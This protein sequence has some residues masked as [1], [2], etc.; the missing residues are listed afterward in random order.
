MNFSDLQE[1]CWQFLG[2]HDTGNRLDWARQ[3]IKDALN[4]TLDELCAAAPFQFNLTREGTI[5]LVNGTA[6]YGIDDW[7]KR[8]IEFWTADI[9]AHKVYLRLPRK[10]DRDGARNTSASFGSLGPYEMTLAPRTSTAVK[11]GTAASATEGST[12]VTKVGGTD[13]T[14][15]DIGRMLRLNGE[16]EDYKITAVGGVT[17]LTVDKA[18]KGRLSGIGTTGTGA[19]Y[20]SVRWEVGPPGR[21]QIQILPTP[22]V[23]RT[24]N[25]R[26]IVNPRRMISQDDTPEV[27]VEYHHLLWKGALRMIALVREDSKSR[28]EFVQEYLSALDILRRSDQDDADSED[29]AHYE[30]LLDMHPRGIPVDAAFRVW[31]G[32]G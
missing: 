5:A 32:A 7:V 24:L 21:F 23:A 29:P 26:A 27:A 22:N 31:P 4:E 14:S 25:Y 10:A 11:S 17:S 16:A 9:A 1:R 18:V 13:W 6:T 3:N 20:S 12:T 30:T 19:G 2:Y 28:A 15:A 8:P